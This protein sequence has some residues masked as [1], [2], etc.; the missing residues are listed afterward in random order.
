MINSYNNVKYCNIF[1]ALHTNDGKED[2][3]ICFDHLKPL[4]KYLNQNF[5]QFS[6]KDNH[7]SIAEC[8]IPYGPPQ[9]HSTNIKARSSQ[10][11]CASIRTGYCTMFDPFVSSSSNPDP[12][13]IMLNYASELQR[14]RPDR[15]TLVFENQYEDTSLIG[16]LQRIGVSATGADRE[17]TGCLL[18]PALGG[19][20]K[21]DY[22]MALYRISIRGKKCF[23][24]VL[25][26]ILDIILHNAWQ[27]HR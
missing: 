26:Y 21:L 9:N 19:V 3:K 23:S 25:S 27:L 20:D 14:Q 5:M 8:T 4:V 15:Y 2:D 22:N 6:P 17:K 7:H 11:W 12:R 16:A 18:N 10:V 13:P 24:A 1:T